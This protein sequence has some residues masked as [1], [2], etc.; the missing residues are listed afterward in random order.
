MDVKESFQN[1]GAKLVEHLDKI[2]VVAQ[3]IVFLGVGYT[4]YTE[5]SSQPPP[6]QLP[7]RVEL[8]PFIDT[9]PPEPGQTS[10]YITVMFLV[11]PQDPLDESG[12]KD[13]GNF[14]MFDAMAVRDADDLQDQ[15]RSLVEQAQRAYDEGRL[16]DSQNLL[17]QALEISLNYRPAVQLREQMAEDA[18]E[19]AEPAAE[20]QAGASGL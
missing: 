12:F 2:L 19:E 17:Q 3:G 8:K 15:A 1:F 6:S 4:Y 5:S 13:L 20:G 9:K 18:K 14:N 11:G 10:D 7:N 16:E